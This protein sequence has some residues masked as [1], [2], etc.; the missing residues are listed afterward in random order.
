MLR[1]HA[2]DPPSAPLSSTTDPMDHVGARWAERGSMKQFFVIAI[3]VLAFGQLASARTR[4]IKGSAQITG[5]LPNQ[6]AVTDAVKQQLKEKVVAPINAILPKGGRVT[7]AFT[8]IGSADKSGTLALNDNTGLRRAEGVAS[9]LWEEF[10]WAEKPVFRTNGDE[11]N[12]RMVTVTWTIAIE[13]TSV[14]SPTP[15]GFRLSRDPGI[16]T[17]GLVVVVVTLIAAG[18]SLRNMRRKAPEQ[19]AVQSVTNEKI[20]VDGITSE[21]VHCRVPIWFE[22]GVWNLPFSFKPNPEA[23]DKRMMFHKNQKRAEKLVTSILA[24]P[25]REAEVAGLISRDVIH[26]VQEVAQCATRNA[27]QQQSS[28]SS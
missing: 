13:D 19:Q 16:Q 7:I 4:T 6:I 3:L 12:S 1:V 17:G 8:V 24:W 22:N 25:E 18:L 5:Y 2:V 21:G 26:I 11:P 15:K 14:P 10:P 20:F 23:G 28:P 27:G 9:C